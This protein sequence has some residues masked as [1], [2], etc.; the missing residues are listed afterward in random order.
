MIVKPPGITETY[1][2]G[3]SGRLRSGEVILSASISLPTGSDIE[4]DSVSVSGGN[5]VVLTDVSGGVAGK[6][7]TGTISAITDTPRTLVTTVFFGVA[8]ADTLARSKTVLDV[9]ALAR[10]R[11]RDE[12]RHMDITI[13]A[14]NTYTWEVDD[15]SALW[16]NEELID[17][18]DEARNRYAEIIPFTDIDTID[19]E[20][21]TSRYRYN[22]RILAVTHVR[23]S[24][25]D[26]YFTKTTV[27]NLDRTRE[28]WRAD[29][30]T[31]DCGWLKYSE[32]TRQREIYLGY[33][34]T[35]SH[36][37]Y[38]DI[39]RLPYAPVSWANRYDIL[40]EPHYSQIDRLVDWIEYKA[41]LKR[42][43]QTYNPKESREAYER[44]VNH[45][46]VPVSAD[47]LDARMNMRNMVLSFAP[48]G[49][50]RSHLHSA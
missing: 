5:T 24:L 19:V 18:L 39:E 50:F 48:K 10:R 17:H 22:D 42:D 38:L 32:D 37:L 14:G 4:I 23:S 2:I 11:L 46:G 3:M 40:L 1:N 30:S 44:W 9:I 6:F 29:T 45:V 8:T 26:E 16:T 33:L 35:Q 15:S 13:T 27:P 43:S 34:P 49:P 36:T 25:C 12:L 28:T 7:Y 31:D 21:G 41:K 20:A 47:K